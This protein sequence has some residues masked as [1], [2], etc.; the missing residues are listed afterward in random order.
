MATARLYSLSTST[1]LKY[2]DINIM[3]KAKRVIVLLFSICIVM[4]SSSCGAAAKTTAAPVFSGIKDLDAVIFENCNL[5]ENITAT[6]DVDGDLTSS[7]EVAVLP[8][9]DITNGVLR[10]STV[11]EYQVVYKVKD[12][13]G[14]EARAYSKVIVSGDDN[15]TIFK[16]FDFYGNDLGAADIDC[17]NRTEDG[18]AGSAAFKDYKLVYSIEKFG[19]IDW[20]NKLTFVNLYLVPGKKY[21]VEFKAFA[22]NPLTFVMFININ[23]GSWNPV[24][25]SY[26][27][28][29]DSSKL[30]AF[31]TTTVSASGN[32]A[33][34]LQFG[35]NENKSLPAT[36]IT[37]DYIRIYEA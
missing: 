24:V 28:L 2:K 23:G 31:E 35:S 8:F 7:I 1:T 9:A 19:D 11:G 14:N 15:R 33:L 17:Y 3:N 30:Y 16:A 13:S 25:S 37:F 21:S 5:L 10:P 29:T 20:Y 27:S 18:A 36:Q 32:Y 4:F 26:I 12:K 34:F 6:D 22:T